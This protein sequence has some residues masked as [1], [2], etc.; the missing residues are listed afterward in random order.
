MRMRGIENFN[1]RLELAE[2][3][4]LEEI[5]LCFFYLKTFIFKIVMANIFKIFPGFDRSNRTNTHVRTNAPITA[6]DTT[7]PTLAPVIP[8]CRAQDMN[9]DA[10][11]ASEISEVQPTAEIHTQST[12]LDNSFLMSESNIVDIINQ[13]VEKA[14]NK[15][16]EIGAN[17]AAE[18]A[19]DRCIKEV[20][21]T[22]KN[23][24]TIFSN[25]LTVSN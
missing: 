13:A 1:F 24:F 21:K 25:R 16:V 8:I 6:N 15:V 5:L 22:M 18:K 14:A 19:A 7:P 4:F 12:L 11:P 10:I 23:E 17:K 9:D 3:L 20:V 2:I